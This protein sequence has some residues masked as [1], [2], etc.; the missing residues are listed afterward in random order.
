MRGPAP[1]KEIFRPSA[2]GRRANDVTR[3]RIFRPVE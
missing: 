2:A 1:P 3:T